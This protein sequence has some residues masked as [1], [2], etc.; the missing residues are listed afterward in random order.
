MGQPLR[1]VNYAVNGSGAGHLTRLCAMN[2]WLRRYAAVLDLR[3]EIYFLTSSE[4]DSLLFHEQFASFKLP[5]KTIVGETGIDKLS[6]LALAKQW[7][8]HSLSLIRPDL[9]VVDTFPRG[10]FGE[11]L[12]ALDLCRHKA[13]IHRPVKEE[14]ARRPDFQ[15]MLPLYDV[16]LVPEYAEEAEGVVRSGRGN[17]RFTGP[18]MVRERAELLSPAQVRAHFAAQPDELLVYVSAGGGGD[19]QAEAQLHRTCAALLLVPDVRIIVGAGPLYRGRPLLGER[20][21]WLQQPGVAELMAGFDLAVCAAGYNSFY[22]LMHAGVPTLFLPQDK[23]A[24]EQDRRAERAVQTGAAFRLA[25]GLGPAAD[26]ELRRELQALL[27]RLRDPAERD[28]ARAAARSLAPRNHA[29]DAAAELLRVVLPAHLVDRAQEAIDDELLAALQAD[30]LQFEQVVELMHA[31]RPESAASRDGRESRRGRGDDDNLAAQAQQSLAI[32]RLAQRQQIPLPVT[33]RAVR[34]LAPKLGT[35]PLAERAAAVASVLEALL[36]FADWP[37][38]LSL[39]K[40]LGT[41]RRQRST[42]TAAEL[43]RF[44]A[45]LQQR[46]EDLLRGISYLSLAHGQDATHPGNR[47]LLQAAQLHMPARQSPLPPAAGAAVTELEA[48]K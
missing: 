33:L 47:E 35:G 10:S 46:G 27:A 14:F 6:Y 8:W 13:F 9:L 19:P 20:V 30:A 17:L 5:S 42:D 25:H 28:R 16:I 24:D 36:P 23:V 26:S 40:L 29:R 18:V 11:L 39:V 22:E 34:L 21:V 41:E 1:I 32:M 31:L 38:A 48:A 12:S 15:T 7:V 44:L 2:R 3:A 37:A 45:A 43:G 4:A